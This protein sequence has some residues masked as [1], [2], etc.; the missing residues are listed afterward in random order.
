MS[1]CL[2]KNLKRDWAWDSQNSNI[3]FIFDS[4]SELTNEKVKKSS[5][6]YKIIALCTMQTILHVIFFYI[7]VLS[8]DCYL[9][10]FCTC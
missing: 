8:L 3:F 6:S 5:R 2:F 9:G 1:I 7:Q 4:S 10:L